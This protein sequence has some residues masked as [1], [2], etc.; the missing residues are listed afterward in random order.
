MRVRALNSLVLS[1]HL[2]HSLTGASMTVR[3]FSIAEHFGRVQD[4]V[5]K[6]WAETGFDFELAPSRELYVRVQESGVLF[7]LGA[8]EGDRIAGYST[9]F[10][11]PHHF[12]P[13]ILHC[14]SD[15]LFVDPAYRQS[16]MPGRLIL[17]TEAM[18]RQR[19]AHRI[20][21]HTRA[22][23]RLAAMFEKRGYLPADVCMMKEL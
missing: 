7:A 13:A 12:N 8:F 6:N 2:P 17:A 11:Y 18:A 23:T 9:A 19:G 16:A 5:R 21:W 14:S 10:V 4:L 15:A 1:Y 22:G 3:E 20:T